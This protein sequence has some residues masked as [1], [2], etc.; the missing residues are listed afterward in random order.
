M[1]QKSCDILITFGELCKYTCDQAIKNGMDASKVFCCEDSEE[2]IK[3]LLS[4]AQKGDTILFK[5]SRGMQTEKVLY[6]FEK[7][8]EE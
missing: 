8:W 4:V 7:G 2:A 3:A 5:G 6:G 1:A